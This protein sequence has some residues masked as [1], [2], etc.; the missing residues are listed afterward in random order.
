MPFTVK[1]Y[2]LKLSGVIQD[3]AFTIMQ[4]ILAS[5]SLL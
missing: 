4:D 1:N 5:L 3:L 2:E